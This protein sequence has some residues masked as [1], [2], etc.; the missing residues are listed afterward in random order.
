MKI[1]LLIV[2]ILLALTAIAYPIIW[3]FFQVEQLLH[4]LPYVMS[5]LWLIKSLIQ[6]NKGQRIFALSMAALLFLVGWQRSLDMM[7]WYPILMNG[8]ML[9]LFGGSLFQSQSLVERLARLQTPNLFCLNILLSTLFVAFDLLEYWAIYTGVI[10]YIIMGLVMSIEWL[11]RQRVK[12]NH[13]E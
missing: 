11:I 9:V 13:Y 12:R 7:Y 1:T 8:I 5:L 3:L 2:N 4:T 10:S 6:P